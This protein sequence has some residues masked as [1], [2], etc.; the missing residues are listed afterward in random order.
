M[1]PVTGEQLADAIEEAVQTASAQPQRVEGGPDD[2]PAGT[3]LL[4]H[5]TEN[6]ILDA[7]DSA[8]AFPLYAVGERRRQATCSDVAWIGRT[9]LAVVNMYGQHLRIYRLHEHD[10]LPS[11][12]ELLH[13]TRSVTPLEGVSVSPDLRRLAVT[14]SFSVDHGLSIHALD[15]VS[16][17]PGP[18][19]P[20]R[21]GREGG[22]YHGV[23]FAPV[24]NFLAYTVIG[25]VPSVE[26]MNVGSRETT[27]RIDF[28]AASLSQKSVTF[29]ADG[30]FVLVAHGLVIDRIDHQYPHGGVLTIHRFDAQSGTIDPEPAGSYR[31]PER[32]LAFIDMSIFLPRVEEGSYRV[33][34]ADQGADRVLAFR[35][36]S[37]RG[38]LRPDGTFAQDLSFPHGI[39]A[40]A[41]GRYVAITT[42]GDDRIHIARGEGAPGPRKRWRGR[43]RTSVRRIA[44]VAHAAGRVI[45]GAERSYVDILAA[46]DRSRFHVTCVLPNDEPTYRARIEGF[47][48]QVIAF[49]YGW[50]SVVPCDPREVE[51]F[52]AVF[53]ANRIDLVHVNTITL[54]APLLAASRLGIPSILHARELIDQ[55][56][57]FAQALGG[58][59]GKIEHTLKA[60]ADFII[61]NS[62]ATHRLFGKP[63]RSMRLYNCIDLQRFDRPNVLVNGKL[64]VGIVGTVWPRKGTG[65]FVALAEMARDRRPELEFHIIGPRN[66]E[67]DEIERRVCARP[68][69]LHL[70]DYIAES[71]DAIGQ[72]NVVMSL[73]VIPES[74][75]RTIAEGMAMRRPVIAYNV[76]AASELIRHGRDG[77]L[78]PHRDYREAFA[79]LEMLATSPQTVLDM[80]DSARMRAEE[81]FA[82]DAFARALNGF[83][84]HAFDSFESARIPAAAPTP[85]TLP[86][87]AA[88]SGLQ[89]EA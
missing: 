50:R 53:Q 49:P 85:V 41:D 82:P 84:D 70:A 13:E 58:P 29:S 57:Q 47:A 26:V 39:D 17:L 43:P 4:S 30:R 73:S 37:G 59:P 10:G 35:F 32:Q 20:V 62:D 68:G 22:A 77:F 72:L 8:T 12:L 74:F 63:R 18:A 42:Y 46:I 88:Q 27:C 51:R 11:T 24:G 65:D 89:A 55:D 3:I 45:A 75:G 21:K 16:Y 48:D 60:Q 64:K 54:L 25:P 15:P 34:V 56:E 66:V 5:A 14:H 2:A 78:I 44:V 31:A 23:S 86:G 52:A 69:N 87:A 79:A 83:Y 76:G 36:D 7:Q 38:T 80:G 9:H 71:A 6:S 19:Q 28:P 81:L 61:A 40:S 1:I 67:F 33:L